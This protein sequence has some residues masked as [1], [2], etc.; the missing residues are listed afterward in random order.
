MAKKQPFYSGPFRGSLKLA[1]YFLFR[2]KVIWKDKSL[3]KLAKK[4]PFVF[5]ANHTN[6]YDGAFAGMVLSRFKT[7]VLVAKDQLEKSYGKFIKLT[8]HV[9]VDRYAPD[10]DWYIEATEVIKSGKS[11]LIFPEGGVARDG[12]M[13][14]F[15]PGAALLAATTGAAI[16]PCAIYGKYDMV[17]GK[18]QRLVIG[19]PI[20][21]NCP[22]DMRHSIYAKQQIALAQQ[23]V[24]A[25]LDEIENK[26][27]KIS[28]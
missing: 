1:V 22:A 20:E 17:F 26:P 2:P 14:D 7:Y 23:Q 24:Q 15:K 13:K 16:V 21:M 5:V 9:Q 18:R 6:Y 4:H 10:A 25:L 8:H 28:E 12:V 19:E 27:D 3:K 11:M